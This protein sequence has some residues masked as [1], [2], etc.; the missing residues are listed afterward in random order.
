MTLLETRG[1]SPPSFCIQVCMA[2]SVTKKQT[3]PTSYSIMS[4]QEKQWLCYEIPW[5]YAYS[6]SNLFLAWQPVVLKK[7]KLYHFPPYSCPVSSTYPSN[8]AL[9]LMGTGRGFVPSTSANTLV[10]LSDSRIISSFLPPSSWSVCLPVCSPLVLVWIQTHYGGLCCFPEVPSL[11]S[12]Y[13]CFSLRWPFP[14][15]ALVT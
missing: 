1:P 9:I 12:N 13:Y 2:D 15:P 8:K 3:A 7:G 14:F 5:P 6:G 4:G 11:V 10:V